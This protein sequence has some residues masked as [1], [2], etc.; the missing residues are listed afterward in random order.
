[1]LSGTIA[2]LVSC[3]RIFRAGLSPSETSHILQGEIVVHYHYLLVVVPLLLLGFTCTYAIRGLRL[4]MMYNPSMRDRWARLLKQHSV[5]KSL[6]ALFVL[7]E[8]IAW[9]SSVVLGLSR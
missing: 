9:S 3:L 5:I 6:V 8:I 1:M 7:V 4:L 2:A